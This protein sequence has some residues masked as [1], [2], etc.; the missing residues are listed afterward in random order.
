MD[1]RSDTQRILLSKVKAAI[2]QLFRDGKVTQH[3]F[4]QINH[5]IEN[6]NLTLNREAIDTPLA[7]LIADC[8]AQN[9]GLNLIFLKGV[10][11][12]DHMGVVR[13]L[14]RDAVHSE[15]AA[16]DLSALHPTYSQIPLTFLSWAQKEEEFQELIRFFNDPK[17]PLS[18]ISTASER[19][20]S[21]DTSD[22]LPPRFPKLSRKLI[23]QLIAAGHIAHSAVGPAAEDLEKIKKW[24]KDFQI[25]LNERYSANRLEAADLHRGGEAAFTL[26]LDQLHASDVENPQL[27]GQ[28]VINWRGPFKVELLGKLFLWGRYSPFQ[29]IHEIDAAIL[30]ITGIDPS[31]NA[32]EWNNWMKIH[33][34]EERMAFNRFIDRIG[35][36]KQIYDIAYVLSVSKIANL[37]VENIWAKVV[38]HFRDKLH[39]PPPEPPRRPIFE[40]P[41][42]PPPEPAPPPIPEAQHPPAPQAEPVAQSTDDESPGEVLLGSVDPEFVEAPAEIKSEEDKLIE[43]HSTWRIYFKPFLSENWL[44][45]IG[46]F[47]LMAAWLFLSMALWEKGELFRILAWIIPL[48]FLTLGAAWIAQFIEKRVSRGA[49]P[50]AVALFAVLA[51]FSIP[52]NF[53]SGSTLLRDGTGTTAIFS[54]VL[55]IGYF[56]LLFFVSRWIQTPFGH[57]PIRFLCLGNAIIYLPALAQFFAHY[58]GRD[59]TERTLDSFGF[60]GLAAL[61]YGLMRARSTDGPTFKFNW[62]FL[63]ASTLLGFTI[64]HIYYRFPPDVGM[65]AIL[66]QI[67]ALFI[68]RFSQSTPT[69]VTIAASLSVLGILIGVNS[70]TVLPI[71]VPLATLFWYIQYKRLDVPW[72]SEAVALH[73]VA[74]PFSL[75]YHWRWNGV[76]QWSEIP[77]LL[78]TGLGL[79][80]LLE[81]FVVRREVRVFSLI[82]PLFMAS[83]PLL[84]RGP[85]EAL[86]GYVP[87]ALLTLLGAYGYWRYIYWYRIK[88]W[89]LNFAIICLLGIPLLSI[90][91]NSLSAE[92]L[93]YLGALSVF[94]AGISTLLRDVFSRQHRTSLLWGLC[95]ASITICIIHIAKL[96]GINQLDFNPTAYLTCMALALLIAAKRAQSS[97]PAYIL[98]I[99]SGLVVARPLLD[100][101][102][103]GHGGLDAAIAVYAVLA[104]RHT[105]KRLGLWQNLGSPELCLGRGF[106]LRTS[107]FIGTPLLHLSWIL[108][109]CSLSGAFYLYD[110]RTVDLYIAIALFLDAALLIHFAL[111]YKASLVGALSLVPILGVW[112]FALFSVPFLWRPHVIGLS[113]F[114]LFFLAG[115]LNKR[116][117]AVQSALARPVSH[118]NTGLAYLSIP[119]GLLGYLF[120]FESSYLGWVLYGLIALLYTHFVLL[121]RTVNVKVAVHLVLIHLGVVWSLCFLKFLNLNLSPGA[122][123][124]IVA[125]G[126]P[127]VLLLCGYV[128]IGFLPAQF[129]ASVNSGSWRFYG[130]AAK[131]WFFAIS[132]LVA[133]SLLVQAVL[134]LTNPPDS[135]G[136]LGAMTYPSIGIILLLL[137]NYRHHLT[138]PVFLQ[139]ALCLLVGTLLFANEMLLGLFFGILL[140]IAIEYAISK[141]LRTEERDRA[142]HN[143]QIA[144]ILYTFSVLFL[145]AHLFLVFAEPGEQQPHYL[146][147]TL[148]P[149]G[150]F[151]AK[152]FGFTHLRYA[153]FGLFAYANAFMAL[154]LRLH[155]SA[156]GLTEVHLLNASFV[157]SIFC[158]WLIIKLTASRN[159]P[160][161]LGEEILDEPI[162]KDPVS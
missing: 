31:G 38:N 156:F 25:Q 60:I 92:L 19:F 65:G 4:G 131:S 55:G 94:W 114:L 95:G 117:S 28:C 146:L 96:G 57:N 154:T 132:I 105:L 59:A 107:D 23:N 80:A 97:L 53:L 98:F 73:V 120:L 14:R 26:L 58:Y 136:P 46:V 160:H 42:Q 100:F 6:R 22:A 87:L 145:L 115:W 128:G 135:S 44:G 140:F 37:D 118:F 79:L 70:P 72:M 116:S 137:G 112:G 66:L 20:F 78:L 15:Q 75:V 122:Q 13:K 144:Y 90:P 36:E 149:I 11:R 40:V 99:F 50:R 41:A 93:I 12:E 71:C 125:M 8:E 129:L 54:L 148:I 29:S 77:F 127:M 126:G 142:D 121:N 143:R 64:V 24:N 159:P 43:K 83:L 3:Q 16:V 61:Y 101:G 162:L 113:A 81:K 134:P 102:W 82:L 124:E 151:L 110:P 88:L 49:S 108:L 18:E 123:G 17:T 68:S 69:A 34:A 139:S 63:S 157:F 39:E 2:L 86:N 33:T 74:L 161:P 152:I 76:P 130:S 150:F 138:F 119:T 85:S 147:Y 111:H 51:L 158:Y 141:P 52:F 21:L 133:L 1:N 84:N 56:V 48:P 32:L 109:L 153:Y 104:L 62:I 47:S 5:E 27:V 91:V 9:L 45:L 7:E 35:E 106:I 103:D 155:I 10:M 89:F 30:A 67:V